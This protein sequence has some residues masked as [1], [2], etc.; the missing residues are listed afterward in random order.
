M[1]RHFRLFEEIVVED[2]CPENRAEA[3]MSVRK[4]QHRESDIRVTCGIKTSS[5]IN[6]QLQLYQW[7]MFILGFPSLYYML[8][9]HVAVSARNTPWIWLE[10]CVLYQDFRKAGHDQNHIRKVG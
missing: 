5:C 2:V 4:C 3:E 6:S 9:I 7:S 10:W 1:E 8:Q